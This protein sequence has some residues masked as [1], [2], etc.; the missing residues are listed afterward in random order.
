MAPVK[1][2]QTLILTCSVCGDHVSLHYYAGLD[3]C[4]D[5]VSATTILFQR[6]RQE[7]DTLHA[8]CKKEAQP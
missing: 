5:S 4:M 8:N 7:L 6:L 1:P 3:S 2:T